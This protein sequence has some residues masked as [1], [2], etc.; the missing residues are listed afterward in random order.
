ML[1]VLVLVASVS[2]LGLVGGHPAGA[3]TCDPDGDVKFVCGTT[4]PEDLYEVPGAWVI[5]SGRYSD[6]EG[7]VYAVSL[8][9]HSVQEIFPAGAL[10][11]EH[12]RDT[13]AACPG[14]NNVFQPHGLTLREGS[15][16]VHTLY[17]VG[18]GAREAIEI[19]ALDVGG[20]VPTMKWIGC[21][22]SPEGTARINSIT[23][24]PD[25]YLG[26]TNFDR[27]GGELWEWHP[28][29]DWIEVPGSQ[30]PGPN[31][32]VSSEDGQWFYVGGWSDRALVRVSRGQT[33]VRVDRIP[34]GFNVD[35]V[36]WGPAG[37]VIAAGHVT[38][39]EDD[40]PCEL[41]AARVAE[42]DPATFEVQQL[43]DY[44]GNEFFQIGTVAI[45]VND[46]IWI[47]GIRG[48]YGIPRFPR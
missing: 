41:S 25:G 16:D 45:E 27:E 43:V 19:F 1:R 5:A 4:N 37:K 9:D 20:A 7:P 32:L 36:R 44:K 30:M 2:V 39:C 8:R 12:D 48:S 13:Y 22:P 38:R 34:V 40:D 29:T 18:H 35:N 14:P 28:T 10:A 11:P 26:A 33:P 3:Q 47:G 31:G 42:V 6:S 21:I 17:V 46:E 24:L 23:A 15:G